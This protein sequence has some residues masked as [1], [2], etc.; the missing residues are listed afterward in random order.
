MLMY[1]FQ[2]RAPIDVNI[3]HDE[4]QSMQN[5][6]RDMQDVLHIAQD[7]IKTAQD[8]AVLCQS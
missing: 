7:N 1:G 5:F 2:A 3:N 8:R 4:L 6:L